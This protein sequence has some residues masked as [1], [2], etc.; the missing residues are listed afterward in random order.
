M[1]KSDLVYEDMCKAS[2]IGQVL[3]PELMTAESALLMCHKLF[4]EIFVIR[5]D[6]TRDKAFQLKLENWHACVEGM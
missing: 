1:K 2:S 6:K 4:G 5:D 3:V